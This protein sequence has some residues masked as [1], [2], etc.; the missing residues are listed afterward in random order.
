MV[1]AS[2]DVNLFY[3]VAKLPSE[4]VAIIIGYLPKCILPELLYF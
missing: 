4:V 1:I 3:E 2:R